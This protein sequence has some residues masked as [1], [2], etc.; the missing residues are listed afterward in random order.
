M[1]NLENSISFVHVYTP[2]T[3]DS[4]YLLWAEVKLE[5][6]A[7]A[8]HVSHISRYC[9]CVCVCVCVHVCICVC[10]CSLRAHVNTCT[11]SRG[12]Q[13]V[14]VYSQCSTIGRGWYEISGVNH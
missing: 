14:W 3:V 8:A 7:V 12:V 9:V 4:V 2:A 1:Q 10:V 5:P 13:T 6:H 11:C